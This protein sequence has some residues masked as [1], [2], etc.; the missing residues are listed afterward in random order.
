MFPAQ[1]LENAIR[2]EIA[3]AASDRP[4]PRGA[5]EPEVDSLTMVRV[6]CRVEEELAIK[7]PDDVM[8]RGGFDNVDHCVAVVMAASRELWNV[9]KPVEERV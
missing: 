9:N 2:D 6:V 8:P 5:W 4:T 1:T 7:L 3:A